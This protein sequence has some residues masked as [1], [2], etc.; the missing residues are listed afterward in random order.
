MLTTQQLYEANIKRA[1]SEIYTHMTDNLLGFLD[2]NGTALDLNNCSD[3]ELDN[4][5]A[6]QALEQ[7]WI[8]DSDQR[9]QLS[10]LSFK[11]RM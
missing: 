2:D 10:I 5:K 6:V 11:R 1:L 8:L 9:E 4:I 7:E 3:D